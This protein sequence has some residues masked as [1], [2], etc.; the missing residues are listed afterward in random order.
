VRGIL[1]CVHTAA[2]GGRDCWE[3][4]SRFGAERCQ[5]CSFSLDNHSDRNDKSRE[6]PEYF[7][8]KWRASQRIT[9]TSAYSASHTECYGSGWHS[10]YN[11]GEA[12]QE[13]AH[14]A[15]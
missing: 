3:L 15:S 6:W 13:K 9:I 8:W 10:D 11:Q 2:C 14:R 4:E 5:T 1:A 7:C 12:T